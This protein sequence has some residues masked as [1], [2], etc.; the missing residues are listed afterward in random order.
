MDSPGEYR[1]AIEAL[2]PIQRNFFERDFM[3]KTFV[4]TK[5]QIRYRLNAILENPTLARLFTSPLTKIDLFTELNSQ[6]VILIDTAKDFLK[7]AS[8]HFG[9][10]FISLVLQAVLER[11]AIPENQRR[12]AFLI[13]DEA[14]AYFDSNID[15]LL[16]EARK[17]KVGCVFAHQFLDQCAHSLRA[18]L[19]ANTSIKMAA[20]VSMNDARAMAPDLRST[21]E[22]ILS[23]PKLHFACHIRNVTRQAVSVPV[24]VGVLEGQPR[25]SADSYTA[26]RELNRKRV[27]L[28][29]DVRGADFVMQDEGSTDLVA[30]REPEDD[31]TKPSSDW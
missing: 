31:P 10:I 13:V 6:S 23:Q 2:P 18:S 14:A 8:A 1:A 25:L 11:A 3:S 7:G 21:P 29:K 12:P 27:S 5:E 30:S 16:T 9:R 22:F 4:Q 28:P 24:E 26:L 15:D 17:Y 20:G 19:A